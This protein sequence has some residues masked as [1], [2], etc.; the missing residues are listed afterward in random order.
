MGKTLRASP[1]VPNGHKY[2]P[3]CQLVLPLSL[4]NR[5]RASRDGYVTDCKSC[6]SARQ[7]VDYLMKKYGLTPEDFGAMMKAQ[8]GM[9]AICKTAPGAHID[10]DH[11]T[12]K[13][14]G[15]LCINCNQGIGKLL[16]D[17]ATLESAI[18][19]LRGHETPAELGTEAAILRLE[20]LDLSAPVEAARIERLRSRANRLFGPAS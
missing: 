12:G 18:Q 8:G 4:W 20:A 13:I 7:R 11:S 19:Y 3:T 5:N 1:D 10:H 16:D 9:C 14:R 6:R 15:I 2:C 17:I